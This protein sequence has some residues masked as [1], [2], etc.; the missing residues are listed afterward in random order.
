MFLKYFL[1]FCLAAIANIYGIFVGS[2]GGAAIMMLLLVSPYILP[3][4]TIM[5]GTLFLA[6]CIPLGAFNVYDFYENNQIDFGVAT[7]LVLG[8]L[9]GATIA[10]KS[11]FY[12]NKLIGEKNAD[13]IKYKITSATYAI[14]AIVYIYLA[15]K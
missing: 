13:I 15:Y 3:S 7:A 11:V 6:T 9:V 10:T 14:L 12:F 5:A 8:L 4:V 1:A 2:G